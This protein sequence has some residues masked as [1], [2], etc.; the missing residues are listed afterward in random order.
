MST[1]SSVADVG[2]HALIARVRERVP[3]APAWVA[4]GLGDDAAVVEPAR[5]LLEVATTDALVE[6]VHFDRAFTPPRAIGHRAL[7]VNL[8]DLAAMGASPRSALL[9]LVL[10]PALLVVDFEAIVDGFMAL[11]S[12]HGVALIGGNITRSPGPLIVDV[13][14]LGTA[15]RRR[16]L[17]RSGARPGDE[18]WV[19]GDIGSA[20]A[21]LQSLSA[22]AR[23]GE[24]LPGCEAA[25][26][27]PEPRVRLGTL[28]GRNRAATACVDLSDGL[29]DGLHQLATAS[30]VG[31]EIE[32]SAVPVG[33]EA[34][35]WFESRGAEPIMA[36]LTGGDDYELLFT[37]RPRSR[38]RLETVRRQARG[39][40][41]TKIGT[42]R[43]EAGVVITRGGVAEPVPSGYVHFR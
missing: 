23:A 41:L 21:G 13:T 8:S 32:H 10:P 33:G 17:A 19:S 11:A 26:L 3:P 18:V 15:R 25:F 34:R 28:L 29:A 40:R 42:V 1:P 37:V 35:A 24:G 36:A 31:I 6:S 22:G 14:A 9:S 30:G 20:A 16:V 7:A 4:I 12:A 5:N 39:L 27:T 43:R 2:E 38:S